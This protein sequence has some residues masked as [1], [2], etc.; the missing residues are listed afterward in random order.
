MTKRSQT[1]EGVTVTAARLPGRT[2]GD[3]PAEELS[4]QAGGVKLRILDSAAKKFNTTADRVHYSHL[5]LKMDEIPAATTGILAELAG[6]Q[7]IS[8]K[9]RAFLVPAQKKATQHGGGTPADG[10]IH[11][12]GGAAASTTDQLVAAQQEELRALEWDAASQSYKRQSEKPKVPPTPKM[13]Q[14]E[15]AL[16]KAEAEL[17]K[18][19][20]AEA[21]EEARVGRFT[22]ET[23]S[24][25][26]AAPAPAAAD[27]SWEDEP[28]CPGGMALR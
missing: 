23:E 1:R 22:A 21:A 11:A 28:G 15:A 17:A 13:L 12:V 8:S 4:V 3:T 5:N 25:R 24:V 19:A 2:I 6:Y 26:D 14:A 9:T 27:Y 10:S 16:E 18:A 7:P 20:R